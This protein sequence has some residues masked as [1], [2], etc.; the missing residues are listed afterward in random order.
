MEIKYTEKSLYKR[1]FAIFIAIA[2]F[3]LV[4]IIK[5]FCLTIVDSELLR[6]RA[7]SQWMRGLP[8]TANRGSIKDRNGVVLASSY[9]T[10]DV[11]VRPADMEDS[12]DMSIFLAKHLE[13]SKEKIYEKIHNKRL[14]EIK[15][16]TSVSKS[17]IQ[18]ILNDYK[19]GIFFAENTE[20]NYE[21]KT[22]LSQIIGFVSGDGI[23]QTGIEKQYDKYLSGIDGKSYVE[24]DLKGTTLNNSTTAY[25]DA[26]DGLDITLTIDYTIQNILEEE[27][28]RAYLENSA[29]SATGIVMNPKTGEILGL[30]IKPSVDL[31]DLPR[32]NIE[33][34]LRLSKATAITDVYEPGSTFKII[35]TAIA[36][37]E[38]LTS[39]HDYF[40]CPGFRV[41]NGVKINCHR[42]SGHGSQSLT[43]GLCN[44][45]NCVFMELINRIGLQK[46]YNYLE[47]FH[48]TTGYKLD[49]PGEGKAVV[50]PEL[51]VTAGDLFRMG[52][53]QSIAITPMGLITS[54]SAIANGG[55]LMQPYF[56]KNINDKY[57]SVVYEKQDSML[58]RVVSESVSKSLSEML[59][60]VVSDGGGKKAAVAG[61]D[62]A[63]KT[64]TA[65]KY[66]NGTIALGKYVASFIGYAPYDDP[67]Y[68]VLVIIDEPKGAY[69]GGTIAAPVA[70]KIFSQIFETKGVETNNNLEA[71]RKA[72]E[73][74]IELPNFVGMTLTQAVQELNSLGLQY[75]IQGNGNRVTSQISPPGTFVCIGD[76]VLLIFE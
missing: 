5:I 16:A 30:S 63:G 50:M 75:L 69:Y 4:I 48:L 52:F 70:G 53:G 21:Y 42:R 56:V 27:I 7:L 44:S 54:V 71:D 38:G 73:A 40:Y 45:C 26:I 2:F 23:G 18:A 35:T 61:Y 59:E 13:I 67:D 25:V 47:K 58:E 14:S 43:K 46:F 11:Y 32:D 6:S 31:S 37:Q 33:E 15:I 76:I 74:N 9:T 17:T 19:S 8:L 12:M 22:M 66:E 29:L 34:L 57:G 49:Y 36:M 3:V 62:I 20:R 51:A 28:K 24:S 64:G 10:Y 55:K 72:L 39:K 1:L 60:V 68:I 65:Q 41:V